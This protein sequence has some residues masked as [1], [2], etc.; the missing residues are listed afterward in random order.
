MASFFVLKTISKLLGKALV[1]LKEKESLAKKEFYSLPTNLKVSMQIF[2]GKTLLEIYK[3]ENRL[4][5]SNK[6]KEEFNEEIKIIFKNKKS[7]SACLLGKFGVRESFCRHDILLSGNIN[8]AIIL[9]RL[10]EIAQKYLLPRVIT[11]KFLPKTPK[12]FASIKLYW[13][14]LFGSA[15]KLQSKE[16]NKNNNKIEVKKTK[17]QKKKETKEEINKNKEKTA[18]IEIIDAENAENVTEIEEKSQNEEVL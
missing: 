3:K 5:F 13:F 10:I 16:N 1:Y 7:A 8:T 6:N 15:N 9:V 12:E 18:E 2:G 14:V 17:L 4:T 11:K